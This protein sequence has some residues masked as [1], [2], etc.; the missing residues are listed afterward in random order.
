[1]VTV[2]LTFW[3]ATGLSFLVALGIVKDV[4]ALFSFSVLGAFLDL[5]VQTKYMT[6][7]NIAI[8]IGAILEC[9]E[10]T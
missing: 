7:E 8:G 1:M 3:Q 9:L 5:N 6:A 10:M 4:S 2:F